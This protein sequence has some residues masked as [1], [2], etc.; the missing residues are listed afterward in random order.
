MS[1]EMGS[2]FI[3]MDMIDVGEGTAIA[4]ATTITVGEA[5]VGSANGIEK[6]IASIPVIGGVVGAVA[7]AVSGGTEGVL[8]G[9]EKIGVPLMFAIVIPTIVMGILSEIRHRLRTLQRRP[10]VFPAQMEGSTENY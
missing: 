5:A 2:K 10:A 1:L 3:G 4:F 6:G 7:G 9:I 8:K